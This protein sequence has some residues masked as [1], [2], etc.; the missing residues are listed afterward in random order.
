MAT[1]II[2]LVIAGLAAAV[3]VHMVRQRKSG[4]SS[5]GCGCEACKLGGKCH[6]RK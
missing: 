6:E 5:C 1:I 2:S 3:V 4:K